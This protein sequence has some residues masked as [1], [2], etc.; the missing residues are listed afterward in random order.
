M[1]VFTFRTYFKPKGVFVGF[2]FIKEMSLHLYG[3]KKI[4]QNDLNWSV[5]LLMYI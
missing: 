4:V 1:Q 2:L 5:L 3:F